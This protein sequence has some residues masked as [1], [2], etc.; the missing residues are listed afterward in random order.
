[1][2]PGGTRF[3]QYQVSLTGARATLTS[4][5]LFAESVPRTRKYMAT[6]IQR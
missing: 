5:I 4:R 2:K 3:N 1:M 6:L